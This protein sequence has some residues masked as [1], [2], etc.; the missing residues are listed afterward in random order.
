M[1]VQRR[2]CDGTITQY[3][4]N[5]KGLFFLRKELSAIL[6]R[7]VLESIPEYAVPAQSMLK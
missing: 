5:S 4:E 2:G 1:V 7:A 3:S 6:R